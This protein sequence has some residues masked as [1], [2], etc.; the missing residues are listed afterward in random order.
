MA[1]TIEERDAKLVLE[2]S[3][4]LADRRLGRKYDPRSA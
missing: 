1:D 4:R 3:Y 2:L